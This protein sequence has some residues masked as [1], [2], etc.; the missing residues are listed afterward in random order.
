MMPAAGVLRQRDP[1]SATSDHRAANP[2]AH[3]A[4]VTDKGGPDLAA[5]RWLRVAAGPPQPSKAS[6]DA[7]GACQR[8]WPGRSPVVLCCGRRAPVPV[9]ELDH[10]Q[11]RRGPH[12]PH[13]HAVS[14]TRCSS[15][16]G[17]ALVARPDQRHPGSG[18]HT[19][20]S[21][22]TAGG[23][24]ATDRSLLQS[25]CRPDGPRQTQS[26]PPVRCRGGGQHRVRVGPGC[27][28]PRFRSRGPHDER[29]VSRLLAVG[30]YLKI[31]WRRQA[32]KAA[33]QI[34]WAARGSN[35]EP[36]D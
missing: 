30:R 2:T 25:P 35:P 4:T 23:N 31:N 28:Q 14:T 22:Y 1:F 5:V 9:R 26:G 6:V 15:D 3:G 17:P 27:G 24:K 12:S 11:R 20:V 16:A 32:R 8:G 19:L 34:E 18:R 13:L 33:G 29:S 10:V 7:Q 36:A 21:R